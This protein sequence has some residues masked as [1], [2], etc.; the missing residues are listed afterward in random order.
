VLGRDVKTYPH[1]LVPRPTTSSNINA[2]FFMTLY[3]LVKI[4][5]F[6]SEPGLL[7]KAAPPRRTLTIHAARIDENI[8]VLV[9][10]L[11]KKTRVKGRKVILSCTLR[12]VL[13]PVVRDDQLLLI[14]TLAF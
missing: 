13:T 12:S 9:A 8:P 11:W 2:Y 3:L 7:Q 4:H 10:I 14:S 1:A 5:S 6:S